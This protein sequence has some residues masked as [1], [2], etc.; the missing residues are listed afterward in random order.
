[1]AKPKRKDD[2]NPD[3]QLTPTQALAITL[4]LSLDKHV[5]RW[6]GCSDEQ[7]D[8]V[9]RDIIQH[10]KNEC[11]ALGLQKTTASR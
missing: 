4:N 7:L 5:P 9:A 6:P 11:R 3:Y 1:M 8:A 2:F 10:V